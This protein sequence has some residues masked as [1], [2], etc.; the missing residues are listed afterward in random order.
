MV[1]RIPLVLSFRSSRHA[2][3]RFQPPPNIR[4][5]CLFEIGQLPVARSR[6]AE[7]RVLASTNHAG[8]VVLSLPSPPWHTSQ[9]SSLVKECRVSS[10]VVF[11]DAPG[12]CR[13]VA[14]VRGSYASRYVS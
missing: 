1:G 2:K 6:L 5:P 9:G 11:T 3:Q 10:C 8:S 7:E 4:R 12:G 14:S 13:S